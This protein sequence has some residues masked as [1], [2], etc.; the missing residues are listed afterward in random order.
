MKKIGLF[1]LFT[2]ILVGHTIFAQKSFYQKDDAELQQRYINLNDWYFEGQLSHNMQVKWADIPMDNGLYVVGDFSVDESLI[3]IDTKSN[4][5]KSEVDF[6]L[7]HEMCHAATHD[8][9]IKEKEDLHGPHFQ[10]CMLDLAN[11]GAFND[12]W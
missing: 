4:I 6:T 10:K 1:L 11:E 8:I 12:I 9:V 5:T 3:R 2:A 7:F